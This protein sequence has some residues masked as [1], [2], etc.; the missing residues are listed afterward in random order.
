MPERALWGEDRLNLRGDSTLRRRKIHWKRV[1]I[2]GL[3][4]F[5]LVLIISGGAFYLWFRS[6]VGAA[7]ADVD[8]AIIQALEDPAAG[9]NGST[10]GSSYGGPTDTAAGPGTPSGSNIVLLGADKLESEEGKAGRS[11]TV[12]LVH[13]D[14]ENDFLSVL[15]VPRDLKVNVPGHGTQKMNAA[16]T[17]GGAA[18]VIRT[19][20]DELGVDLDHYVEMDFNAFKDITDTLGGV[21]LDVDR[22]YD[23][24]KIQFAPGY[25]LLDG[26]NALRFVR[27]RHDTNLDFGRMQRQQR[28]LSA[29]REQA[30]GWNLPLK[31]PGLIE[32]LFSNVKTDLTANEILKLAYWAVRLDD[33]RVK[34]ASIVADI[35]TVDGVSYVLASDKEISSAVEAF[36]TPPQTA[37]KEPASS[38][39][40]VEPPAATLKV[41]ELTGASVDLINRSSRTGQAALAAVWLS[42]LGAAV[43]SARDTTKH[44]LEG[45]EVAYPWGG[46]AEA[47]MVAEALG[48]ET[49][50]EVPSLDRVTVTLGMSYALSAEQLAAEIAR[51]SPDTDRWSGFAREVAFPLMAP[52]YIPASCTYSYYRAYDISVGNGSKP[53][54]KVGYR[55]GVE[56]QYLSVNAADWL[57][58]PL[59]SAGEE[60]QGNGVVFTVVGTSAK[61]ERVWWKK[62]GVLY[63]VSNTLLYE[64]SKEDLLAVALSVVSVPAR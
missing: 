51:P 2:W 56:D 37:D 58:A 17:Y 29:L 24:G 5:F 53:A 55:Y 33:D 23:D 52:S 35:E 32:S 9:S 21:Y 63:W 54:L 38:G 50:R 59:A 34:M 27:T 44:A 25:Q 43:K 45:T 16:Y 14:P 61:P 11:D 28:F 8:P 62:D 7:N 19:V 41:V 4:G 47:Q 30:M 12:M 42:R 60:V 10:S 46:Q 26:L 13:I 15:S 39:D 31:L 18:L 22:R 49:L 48:I 6:Q 40:Q 36:L 1:A 20:Q 3:V 57:D 64:L